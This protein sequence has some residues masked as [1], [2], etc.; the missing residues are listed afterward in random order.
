ALAVQPQRVDIVRIDRGTTIEEMARQRP[1]PVRAATLALVNQVELQ[2]TL[3]PG[4]LV[5]WIVGQ[6]LPYGSLLDGQAT[7]HPR[8]NERGQVPGRRISQRLQKRHQLAD[9]RVAELER[10]R[11]TTVQVRQHRGYRRV[12]AVIHLLQRRR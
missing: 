11:P 9:L 1:S 2:T 7:R 6:P 8:R 4:R 12:I 3:E 10:L 5:K